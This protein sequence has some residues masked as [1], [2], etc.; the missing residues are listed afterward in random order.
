MPYYLTCSIATRRGTTINEL[1]SYLQSASYTGSREMSGYGIPARAVT[2]S[3]AIYFNRIQFFSISASEMFELEA[4]HPDV[5]FIEHTGNR[6]SGSGFDNYEEVSGSVTHN[7]GYPF[8]G[9]INLYPDPIQTPSGKYFR[10]PSASFTASAVSK[11]NIAVESWNRKDQFHATT[12]AFAVTNATPAWTFPSSELFDEPVIQQRFGGS[13]AS[14]SNYVTWLHT[15]KNIEELYSGSTGNPNLQY[16]GQFML[17]YLRDFEYG[18]GIHNPQ[19]WPSTGLTSSIYESGVLP[20][21]RNFSTVKGWDLLN[22]SPDHP[23]FKGKGVSGSADISLFKMPKPDFDPLTNRTTYSYHLTGKN[24]LYVNF[25]YFNFTHQEYRSLEDGS[26]RLKFINWQD[27]TQTPDGH[28]FSYVNQSGI[29][30]G[31]SVTPLSDHGF[32]KANASSIGGSSITPTPGFNTIYNRHGK[33]TTGLAVGN[34]SFGRGAQVS[35]IAPHYSWSG[36]DGYIS[37]GSWSSKTEMNLAILELMCRYQESQSIDT[38]KPLLMHASLARK[39]TLLP[40]GHPGNG[41]TG[42]FSYPESSQGHLKGIRINYLNKDYCFISASH[43]APTQI[44][45]KQITL[46]PEGTPNSWDAEGANKPISP[47]SISSSVNGPFRKIVNGVTCSLDLAINGRK[48]VSNFYY[49]EG[50]MSGLVDAINK[51][52]N[53][54][55]SQGLNRVSGSQTWDWWGFRGMFHITASYNEDTLI[56]SSSLGRDKYFHNTFGDIKIWTGSAAQFLGHQANPLYQSTNQGSTNYYHHAL[57]LDHELEAPYGGHWEL[58][59]GT[60]GSVTASSGLLTIA[61]NGKSSNDRIRSDLHESCQSNEIWP[62]T[63]Y[64]YSLYHNWD[65]FGINNGWN[66]L[67]PPM[68]DPK[69][70]NRWYNFEKGNSPYTNFSSTAGLGMYDENWSY[71]AGI[72][73]AVQD[74]GSQFMWMGQ[75]LALAW[76]IAA[77]R[78]IIFSKS[79]GNNGQIMGQTGSREEN[80][81]FDP[82]RYTPLIDTY[83]I[84]KPEKLV[85]GSSTF[86]GF[87]S[88]EAHRVPST[89]PRVY[90][91]NLEVVSEGD[92]VDLVGVSEAS[93]QWSSISSSYNNG[94]PISPINAKYYPHE[95]MSSEKQ[96]RKWYTL[97]SDI[98]NGAAIITS[99]LVTA[100]DPDYGQ[101]GIGAGPSG[102]CGGSSFVNDAHFING[103][104]NLGFGRVYPSLHP[105]THYSYGPG[106]DV[107]SSFSYFKANWIGSD[108]ADD[109][110]IDDS[111]TQI[112]GTRSGSVFRQLD[113][114]YG[115]HNHDEMR[116]A[117][118]ASYPGSVNRGSPDFANLENVPDTHVNSS[119]YANWRDTNKE[120]EQITYSGHGG[121]T[122]A[123]GPVTA[124]VIL[125]YLEANPTATVKDVRNFLDYYSKKILRTEGNSSSLPMFH[126][127]LSASNFIPS[128]PQNTDP[129]YHNYADGAVSGSTGNLMDGNARMLHFPW[130]S[131]FKQRRS[132]PLNFK[133]K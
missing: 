68:P 1:S 79:A 84:Y 91:E 112:L 98:H 80:P 99:G 97:R 101:Y 31:D 88:K 26:S 85:S 19:W 86:Y 131:G 133:K 54:Q 121:G 46:A 23:F 128:D 94:E 44:I 6:P 11:T 60:S 65:H 113:L 30:M 74:N 24:T 130:N 14:S 120:S 117:L 28:L 102:V 58:T 111:G 29:V 57:K 109:A 75:T 64:G 56:L 66:E 100:Q 36:L 7:L 67:G 41:A 72:T 73:S 18:Y 105:N 69:N 118:S 50:G 124:G 12:L 8:S 87:I 63:R 21:Y 104:G 32:R 62:Q 20:E 132:G 90:G 15:L 115:R 123:A 17:E 119:S 37:P 35:S 114:K 42:S 108:Y 22:K 96:L 70:S 129:R 116:T 103:P 77:E 2:A 93:T 27:E 71:G 4:N 43:N 33:M 126:G 78:G 34:D 39:T 83:I 89:H 95:Y 9:S 107:Y 5:L 122:S 82:R 53:V 55:Y 127:Y 45:A 48:C 52:H 25:E 61:M 51:V 125:C 110:V 40:Y 106:I 92:Y 13:M 16:G 47:G 81:F 38:R 59:L 76:E 10:I 49:Y 3:S